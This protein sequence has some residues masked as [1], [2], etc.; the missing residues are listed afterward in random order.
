MFKLIPLLTLA[1]SA[2]AWSGELTIKV[3]NIKH[4]G[5]L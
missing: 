2:T 4:A 1:M 3:T 5:V